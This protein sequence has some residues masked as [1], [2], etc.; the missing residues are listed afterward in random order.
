MKGK[1]TIEHITNELIKAIEAGA[2]EWRMPWSYADGAWFP[3]NATTGVAY[4]GG[5]VIS[6]MVE[7]MN[8]GYTNPLWATYKQWTAVGGQVRKGERSTPL[9]FWAPVEKQNA[10]GEVSKTMI[11]NGF[12]VFNIAQQDGYEISEISGTSE[13][14]PGEYELWLNDWFANVPAQ[15]GEGKPCYIPSQDRVLMPP[16][17]AFTSLENYWG[18]LAHELIHWTGHPSRLNRE[19]RTSKMSAEYAMEEL[20]AELGAAFTCGALGVPTANRQ[21][22]HASYLASWVRALK[23][24][25]GILWSVASL[26]QHAAD[27]LW[28]YQ[29]TAIEPAD[30]ELANV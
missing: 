22:D 26:A 29:P 30:K 9:V 1:D 7:Q 20:I 25:P 10:K 15:I 27:H 5:N 3:T 23:T 2:G 19:Q 8:H 18:T 12:S 6:L 24:E 16:K 4:R 28:T 13:L 11:P 21:A 14:E 17:A